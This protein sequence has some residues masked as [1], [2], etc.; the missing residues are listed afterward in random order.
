MRIFT[1]Q[2]AQKVPFYDYSYLY[3][4]KVSLKV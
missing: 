1:P 3:K 2:V 4:E